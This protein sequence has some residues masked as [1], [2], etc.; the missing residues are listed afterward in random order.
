MTFSF[1]LK[2][3]VM[4]SKLSLN[5][6]S[7]SLI[8][9]VGKLSLIRVVSIVFVAFHVRGDGVSTDRVEIANKGSYGLWPT[10]NPI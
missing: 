10:A 6:T 8:E 4:S 7:F 9:V 1:L 2:I 5:L 3:T